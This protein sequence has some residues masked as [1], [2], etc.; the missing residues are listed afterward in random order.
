MHNNRDV[1]HF[2]L[3][4][5]AAIAAATAVPTSALAAPSVYPVGTTIYQPEAAWNGYTVLSLLRDPVMVIDMNGRVVKQWS[6]FNSSA[7]GPARVLPNGEIIAAAGAYQGHQESLQ[8]LQKDFAGNER[9][10]LS[11]E[12][13]IELPRGA[14]GRSLRQHHDWQRADFPGGYYSPAFTPASTGSAT[15]VLTHASRQLATVSDLPLEDDR[16]I[17]YG[18]DGKVLWTWQIS[19]HIDELGFSPGARAAIKA[20]AGG[21]PPGGGAAPGAPP[22]RRDYDWAHVNSAAYLGPNRW[23]DAGDKRFAPENVIISSRQASFL[24]IIA[25]DGH[26]VWRMGPDFR[27]SPPLARIGQIIGQHHA[28]LIPKGLPGEGNLLLFDNG[29]VSGYGFETPLARNG[30][31][32]LAR[33]NSRVL[34]IDPVKLELVWSYAPGD[35]F[36]GTNISGAQRLPNGNTLITE[37]PTGRV[38]EVTSQK[39]IV[40]EYIAPSSNGARNAVYRA[41]RLPYEWIPQLPKPAQQAVVPPSGFS[42]PV[43]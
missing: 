22:P 5:A 13:E 43:P 30:Y 35:A 10:V 38:F 14:K 41:Y 6:G 12:A 37:G 25:R 40:W 21:G 32:G 39:K 27:E 17:E 8:L 15:L 29:G 9:W 26:V 24:A 7:G 23:F 20:G 28:H 36:Y 4:M 2:G 18:A 31:G 1:L 11:G 3:A 33:A 19:D 34:E 16:L 42:A